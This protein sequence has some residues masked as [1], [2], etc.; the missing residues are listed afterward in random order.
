ME[1]NK[2]AEAEEPGLDPGN[3]RIEAVLNE[4][5]A[6]FE[7]GDGSNLLR[8][9][10]VC[11]RFEAVMPEWAADAMLKLEDDMRT[12][13]V[14]DLNAVF[15]EPEESAATRAKR[16]RKKNASSAIKEVL[17]HLRAREGCSLT[18]S[19]IVGQALDMLKARRVH[20]NGRDVEEFLR[21]PEGD[22]IRKLPRGPYP[23]GTNH[24]YAEMALPRPR[25]RG[26]KMFE[27]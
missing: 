3:K 14:S 8:C 1:T 6:A 23:E 5:R 2:S 20:V 24:A 19:V 13:R 21:S 10:F 18:E 27:D 17:F 25:R 16:A 4:A 11:A 7:H 9:L 26:R 22:F 15:G 12:G